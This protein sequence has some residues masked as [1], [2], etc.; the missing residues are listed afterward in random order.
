MSMC[1]STVQARTMLAA[2]LASGNFSSKF[3]HKVAL[4]KCPRAFRLRRLAQNAGRGIGVRHF[5]C[6]FPHKM[7]LIKCPC[8]FRLRSFAQNVCRGVGVRQFSCKFNTKWLFSNVHVHFNGAGSHKVCFPVLGSVFLLNI[9]LLIIIFRL[10]LNIHLITSSPSPSSSSSS[11]SPS[12][13]QSSSSSSSWGT[14]PSS[15]IIIIIITTNSAVFVCLP[16]LF[17]AS[18]RDIFLE[19]TEATISMDES[20]MEKG[21]RKALELQR[22]Q[23]TSPGPRGSPSQM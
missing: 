14:S 12:L 5:S 16:T 9:I 11:S 15:L 10:V 20:N 19:G 8:P 18:C 21:M 3:P 7:A 17:G 22:M 13:S 2:E 1:V 23:I 4:L 6:K